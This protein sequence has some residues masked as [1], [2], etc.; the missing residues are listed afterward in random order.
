[1]KIAQRVWDEATIIR[2]LGWS[3]SHLVKI[4]DPSLIAMNEEL[5]VV[6]DEK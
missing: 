1:V 6:I 2:G 3:C 4:D 5:F